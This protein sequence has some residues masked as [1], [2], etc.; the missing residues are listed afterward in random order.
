MT[1]NDNV[2]SNDVQE[3]F[4]ALLSISSHTFLRLGNMSIQFDITNLLC[5]LGNMFMVKIFIVLALHVL[6]IAVTVTTMKWNCS[7]SSSKRK[8]ISLRRQWSWSIVNVLVRAFLLHAGGAVSGA[9][10]TAIAAAAVLVTPP[11]LTPTLTT[12]VK[13][14]GHEKTPIVILDNV[15]S[16]NAYMSLRNDLRSRNDF[17]EGDANDVSFP[18]KIAIID[19][20]IV[21]PIINALLGN[22]DVLEH[23]PKEIFEQHENTRGFASVLCNQGWVHNDYMENEFGN[24]VA[25]AAVFYLGFDG[26]SSKK[27]NIGTGTAFFREKQSGLERLTSIQ[28]NET[29]FCKEF[30]ESIACIGDESND[31]DSTRFEETFRVAGTPNRLVLYSQ[32]VLHN[33]WVERK[34]QRDG[35]P[36]LPCSA[37]EGRLAIS[38]FF[39]SRH[40]GK[41]IVN[42][43]KNAWKTDATNQLR[44]SGGLVNRGGKIG[45]NLAEIAKKTEENRR[46]LMEWRRLAACSAFALGETFNVVGLSCSMSA[47]VNVGDGEQLRIRGS[48]V[49]SHPTLNRGGVSA[50]AGKT[51]Y[52]RHFLLKGTAKMTLMNM[53][54]MGAWVGTTD[55]GCGATRLQ[56]NCGYCKKTGGTGNGCRTPKR[57][58]HPLWVPASCTETASISVPEDAAACASVL[59]VTQTHGGG[60]LEEQNVFE[61]KCNAVMTA[62]VG[63]AADVGACTFEKDEETCSEDCERYYRTKKKPSNYGQTVGYG[64]SHRDCVDCEGA[65]DSDRD[66]PSSACRR[67]CLLTELAHCNGRTSEL[68]CES[69]ANGELLGCKWKDGNK[70]IDPTEINGDPSNEDDGWPTKNTPYRGCCYKG[71]CGADG[72]CSICCENACSDTHKGGAIRLEGS[73]V[74]ILIDIIFAGNTA[75]GDTG[76]IFSVGSATSL[77]LLNMFTP[78]LMSGVAPKATCDATSTSTCLELFKRTNCFVDPASLNKI[79][80]CGCNVGSYQVANESTTCKQCPIGYSTPQPGAT[81]VGQCDACAPGRTLLDADTLLCQTCNAGYYQPT[82]PLLVNVTCIPCETGLYI[83]DEALD[84]LNHDN[85][86]DCKSCPIGREFSTITT[87]QVCPG[88]Y[89]QAEPTTDG[90]KCSSCSPGRFIADDSD[91]ESYH[92]A[93]KDCLQC[94]TGK[95][96]PDGALFCDN[97]P[98]GYRNGDLLQCIPCK[99]GRYQPSAGKDDCID[100]I[101]GKYQ[102]ENATAFCVPC[103]AGTSQSKEGQIKCLDCPANTFSDQGGQSFCKDCSTSKTSFQGLYCGK[104]PAGWYLKTETNQKYCSRCLAG[105]VSQFGATDCT[106]CDAGSF[107]ILNTSCELCDKG[108]WSNATGATDHS[109]CLPCPAGTFSSAKGVAAIDDCNACS[110]GNFGTISAAISADSGCHKCKKGQYQNDKGKTTCNFCPKGKYSSDSGFVECFACS[111]GKF[112]AKENSTTCMLCPQGWLQESVEG[113]NCSAPPRGTIASGGSSSV[114]I[115][116]GWHAV[117]CDEVTKV[118]LKSEPCRAGTMSSETDGSKISCDNCSAGKTSFEGATSCSACSRGRFASKEGMKCNDCPIGWFQP[119]NSKPSLNCKRCPSGWE[120]LQDENNEDLEGSAGCRDK[121]GNKP[122]DCKDIEYFNISTRECVNCPPGGSCFGDITE[123]GIKS[124]FG[125]SRC[126]NLN[127]TF[128]SC[129]FGAACLGAPNPILRGKFEIIKDNETVHDPANDD[130]NETCSK[131]YLNGG[132]ICASCAPG[133]SHSGL[134]EKCDKCPKDS[135][136][137]AIAI[138]GGIFGIVGLFVYIKMTLSDEGK[139]DPADG[140][141]SIGLSYIQVIS[142]LSKFPIAW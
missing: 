31:D 38:L 97:C 95:H 133:Y 96:S 99:S 109:T 9:C 79:L 40:G 13:Y 105:T 25:P 127:L 78:S 128:E 107:N 129:I 93:E 35:D 60:L 75:Y 47:T 120:A 77:Y 63:D 17:F 104:C 81:V 119:Q 12:T 123:T 4:K 8:R 100:C 71:Y 58:P 140:A 137:I 57:R 15:L 130:T 10:A 121:G 48:D 46:K 88:G 55:Y 43:L 54:L 53:E 34:E 5:L 22:T 70:C 65:S 18:G 73:S 102:P 68:A 28:G 52:L 51:E 87:C 85:I 67:T 32:D 131:G 41:E 62:D 142:L 7:S 114:G 116:E 3:K 14:A 112:S 111:P 90:K 92:D 64:F 30:P 115:A 42:V 49:L 74:A 125:W 122:S 135:E 16:Q 91:D 141:Q 69:P 132:L 1:A 44:G 110:P 113:T 2:I 61:T 108:L 59:R 76:N 134:G 124:L 89:Y 72:C 106:L 24:I 45:R 94:S 101:V 84:H 56:T 6:I 11:T 23:F 66:D 50:D 21:D 26:T 83:D 39:L 19:R 82:I 118:C 103:N 80:Y 136:N 36:V 37:K 86:N 139:I 126:P 117:E 98:T 138:A 27:S 20:P 33:A 29:K